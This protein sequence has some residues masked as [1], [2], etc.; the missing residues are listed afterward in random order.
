MI[1][2]PGDGNRQKKDQEEARMDTM[3]GPTH[4]RTAAV[5]ETKDATAPLNQGSEVCLCAAL[6]LDDG[7]IIRGHRHDDCIGTYG[8]WRNAGQRIPP[9]TRQEQQGFLTSRGRFV[10]REEGARLM[11]A[12]LHH[13]PYSGRQ[14]DADILFSE[15]LY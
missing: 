10:S 1:D 9:L 6:L 15:D 13:S 14:F 11:R 7:R 12:V 4:S 8:K 3:G 5:N 2:P